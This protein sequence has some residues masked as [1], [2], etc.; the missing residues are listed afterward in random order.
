MYT[1]HCTFGID[2][3][4]VMMVGVCGLGGECGVEGIFWGIGGVERVRLWLILAI[5][6]EI[7]LIFF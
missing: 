5:L 7:N 1:V 3:L 6:V 2:L 4:L